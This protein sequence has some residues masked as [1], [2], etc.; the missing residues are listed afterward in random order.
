MEYETL[1]RE[2]Y[3]A[4]MELPKLG[5]VEFTWGN[6]SVLDAERRVV[7]IK[8][9]GVPYAELSAEDIV[10]VDLQGNRVSGSLNPSSDLATHLELYRS[11]PGLL[12]VVH[13]P[14]IWA[15]S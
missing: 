15:T 13:T 10:V 6:V 4:N 7:A 2:T 14:S 9:S 11:F 8:P 12:S 1:R 3:G 5:L